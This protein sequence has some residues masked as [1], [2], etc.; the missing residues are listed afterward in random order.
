MPSR[1]SRS[2][3]GQLSGL[4]ARGVGRA[5]GHRARLECDVQFAA[6]GDACAAWSAPGRFRCECGHSR[7]RR[8]PPESHSPEPGP[9]PVLEPAPP[10]IGA[11]LAGC[12]V[13]G[14]HQVAG[15]RAPAPGSPLHSVANDPFA[16]SLRGR[17]DE[18][19]VVEASSRRAR[20]P[21]SLRS[22]RPAS[23]AAASRAAKS[24]AS[25]SS[26]PAMAASC[27]ISRRMVPSVLDAVKGSATPS[28]QTRV[29]RPS[30]RSSPVIRSSAKI[31]SARANLP[32][33][34]ATIRVSDATGSILTFRTQLR[35]NHLV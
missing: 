8:P 27:P 34:N 1:S 4:Y 11:E 35:R 5:R 6:E 23:A 24:N 20:R 31:R 12:R 18:D 10:D 22:T 2:H 7:A 13:A 16:W 29:R 26:G 28:I 3:S 33:P 25:S 19:S 30:P 21:R 14:T 32:N 17:A 15:A 9:P